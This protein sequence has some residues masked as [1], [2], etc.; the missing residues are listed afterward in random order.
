MGQFSQKHDKEI[1]SKLKMGKNVQVLLFLLLGVSLKLV[2]AQ[3]VEECGVAQMLS[4]SNLTVSEGGTAI[5]RCPLDTATSCLVDLVEWFQVN[6]DGTRKLLRDSRVEVFAFDPL[7]MY[8]TDINRGDQGWYSCVISNPSGQTEAK[9]Y[10]DVLEVPGF[11]IP[12]SNAGSEQSDQAEED[13][14][15]APIPTPAPVPVPAPA[16]APA[17]VES[18]DVALQMASNSVLTPVSETP[19]ETTTTTTTTPRS[20]KWARFQ[21]YSKYRGSR[22]GLAQAGFGVAFGQALAA[23]NITLIPRY[24][25]DMATT[26]T[27]ARTP[28]WSPLDTT[29]RRPTTRRPPPPPPPPAPAPSQQQ[30]GGD[31]K[32]NAV[33]AR[34]GKVSI[35]AEVAAHL[36]NRDHLEAIHEHLRYIYDRLDDLLDR[37]HYLETKDRN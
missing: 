4:W 32:S 28:Y 27:T 16:P 30:G 11:A 29:T 5:Y 26:S 36:T 23:N 10:L 37:V 15:P 33:W 34:G 22:T 21:V 18:R 14:V 31:G 20:N 25:D 8:M 7:L 24:E 2:L 35:P 19:P 9:V 3:E 1:I 13:A 12:T 6:P 17:P